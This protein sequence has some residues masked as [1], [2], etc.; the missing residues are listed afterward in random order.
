VNEILGFDCP[1]RYFAQ[2]ISSRH[3]L[4]SCKFLHIFEISFQRDFSCEIEGEHT[5][6]TYTSVRTPLT[7]SN[8]LKCS[9]CGDPKYRR[10]LI[11]MKTKPKFWL[12]FVCFGI[13][14][15]M[16]AQVYVNSNSGLSIVDPAQG[17][18]VDQLFTDIS[19][20][21]LLALSPDGRRLYGSGL[22][23]ITVVDTLTKTTIATVRVGI[24]PNQVI[25]SLDGNRVYVATPDS[26][27]VA[28]VDALTNSIITTIPIFANPNRLAIAPD[29]SHIYVGTA[30]NGIK[31]IDSSTNTVIGQVVGNGS[32]IENAQ[33][34]G[35]SFSNDGRRAYAGTFGPGFFVIDVQ[36]STVL[37]TVLIP[38]ATGAITSILPALDGTRLYAANDRT[39]FNDGAKAVFVLDAAT[40]SVLTPIPVGEPSA[41]MALS[42]D[43]RQL[44]VG[45]VDTGNLEIIDTSSNRITGTVNVAR[46]IDGGVITGVTTQKQG[47]WPMTGHDPQRMGYSPF[48]G[49]KTAPSPSW[50]FPTGE[51]II[52]DLVISAEGKIYFAS[53]KLY[54]LNLN[55]T[56]YAPAVPISPLTSPA[57]DDINGYI[58]ITAQSAP[59]RYNVLRYSKQLENSTVVFSGAFQ[60]GAIVPSAIVV[61]PDGTI[62]FSDGVSIIAWGPRTWISPGQPFFGPCFGNPGLLAPTLGRDGSVYSMCQSGGGSGFGSGLYRFDG[63]TGAQIGFA[64]YSRGGT[65]LIVDLRNDI[66][67]GFQAFNGIT[68]NGSYD[69]W[70][71]DLNQLT[72]TS[73]FNPTTSRSALMPDGTSTVRIGFSFQTNE[74]DAIGAHVWGVPSGTQ[75]L[76]NFFDSPHN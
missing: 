28:V 49:P 9:A 73:V 38:G 72:A 76:P 58:Y 62:Y 54:A 4:V 20:E 5:K 69:T 42:A 64:G 63:T 12:V 2:D 46:S 68:F 26:F 65:E 13:A 35:I 18:V 30:S 71:A 22:F 45:D 59:G 8:S 74:L 44:Y 47:V 39:S 75:T 43:G 23:G 14:Q 21:S 34:L 3:T 60:F 10:L 19:N 37:N 70:D 61:G 1:I 24:R 50:I 31:I 41:Q 51:P 53:D 32:G 15:A 55:G 7:K 16:M 57:I 52:G 11:S 66:R 67:A 36:T 48:I 25:V 56:P 6:L 33:I 17:N 40:N 27:S 29:G